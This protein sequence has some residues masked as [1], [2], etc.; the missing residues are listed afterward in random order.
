MADAQRVELPAGASV[1]APTT[2][3][4]TVR[5]VVL[6]GL[7]AIIATV[8]LLMLSY[9]GRTVPDSLIAIGSATVGALSALLA[10]TSSPG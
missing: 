1:E 7:L 2:D 3:R 5:L 4:L 8:G 9:H 6:L 10:K